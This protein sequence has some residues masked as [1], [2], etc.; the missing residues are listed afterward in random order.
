MCLTQGMMNRSILER[1]N[2]K[3]PNP[4]SD[5]ALA[6][7]CTCAVLDNHHG[8]GFPWPSV[9]DPSA[10]S[11]SFWITDGCPLHAPRGIME[12]TEGA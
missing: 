7:G 12:P 9:D 6:L 1:N 10:S 5:E 8:K 3:P 11:V 2:V 4:G